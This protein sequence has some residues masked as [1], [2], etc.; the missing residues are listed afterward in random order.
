MNFGAEVRAVLTGWKKKSS[1]VGSM[2]RGY[3]KKHD[4]MYGKEME[5]RH[6]MS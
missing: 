5:R 4:Y 6:F 2:C 3:V 1:P